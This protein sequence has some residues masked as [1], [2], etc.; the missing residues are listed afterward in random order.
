MAAKERIPPPHT[1]P[2]PPQLSGTHPFLQPLSSNK[3]PKKALSKREKCVSQLPEELALWIL[4]C[5][6]RWEQKQSRLVLCASATGGGGVPW[7]RGHAPPP[8]GKVGGEVHPGQPARRLSAGPLG[9]PRSPDETVPKAHILSY[10]KQVHCV[11]PA[12]LYFPDPWLLELGV[13]D[14]LSFRSPVGLHAPA[15]GARFLSSSSSCGNALSS[16]HFYCQKDFRLQAKSY[17]N[18]CLF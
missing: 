18:W 16:R 10:S 6:A 13:S 4:A 11:P 2:P 3:K 15:C 17:R 12:G 8:H 9:T 7:L 14:T 5:E 1:P